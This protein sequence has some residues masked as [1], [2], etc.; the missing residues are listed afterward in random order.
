M[1]S[2]TW[3]Y[4]CHPVFSSP[5]PRRVR[6]SSEVSFRGFSAQ[7]RANHVLLRPASASWAPILCQPQS[8]GWSTLDRRSPPWSPGRH[9]I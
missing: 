4:R 2:L 9:H 3:L 5:Q 6:P 1:D 8:W 7:H